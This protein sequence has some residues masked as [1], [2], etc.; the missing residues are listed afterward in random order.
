MIDALKRALI[1]NKWTPCRDLLDE[2]SHMNVKRSPSGH[3][4]VEHM[5]GFHD[6]LVMAAGIALAVHYEE[7]IYDFP[8]FRKLRVR[9]APEGAA[10]V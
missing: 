4:K 2:M 1:E 8:D 6:D 9:Y 7:P 3:I 5:D 10:Y